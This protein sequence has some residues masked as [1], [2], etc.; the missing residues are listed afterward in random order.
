MTA[1]LADVGTSFL[2]ALQHIFFLPSKRYEADA[3]A[4]AIALLILLGAAV[5]AA[6]D[7]VNAVEDFLPN[8]Y[9]LLW[10]AAGWIAYVGLVWLWRPRQARFGLGRVI[11][12][13]AAIAIVMTVI[14][15][16]CS[17]FVTKTGFWSW[18][19]PSTADWLSQSAGWGYFMWWLVALWRAGRVAWTGTEWRFGARLAVISLVL[20]Y[21]LPIVPLIGGRDNPHPTSVVWD[22]G[23]Y[24]W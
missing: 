18:F 14:W 3:S 11:A 24:G 22:W 19:E 17:F 9:G 1:H 5:T 8:P 4:L 2:R 21:T 16:A 7:A 20:T 15:I 12:D 10:F 23:Q 13:S 6:S